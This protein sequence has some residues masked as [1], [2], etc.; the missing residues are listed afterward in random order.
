MDSHV[1]FVAEGELITLEKYNE[2]RKALA[3][4]V[5]P[6]GDIAASDWIALKDKVNE[7]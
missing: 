1:K 7:G 2:F 6:N 5:I 4:N 3:M